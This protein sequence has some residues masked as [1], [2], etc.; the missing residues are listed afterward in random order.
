MLSVS[1][2][3]VLLSVVVMNVATL[4]VVVPIVIVKFSTDY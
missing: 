4:S 3:I 1:F 2:F